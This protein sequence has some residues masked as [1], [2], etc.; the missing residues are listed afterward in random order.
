[1]QYCVCFES[2]TGD[3]YY[4][5]NTFSSIFLIMLV[6]LPLYLDPQK[7]NFRLSKTVLTNATVNSAE[8]LFS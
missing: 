1:M 2:S 3:D 6:S 4:G 5:S 8:F 7:I